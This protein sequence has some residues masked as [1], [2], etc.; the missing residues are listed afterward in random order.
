MKRE[1]RY[2]KAIENAMNHKACDKDVNVL[3]DH[4]LNHTVFK[5]PELIDCLSKCGDSAVEQLIQ[6]Y[7][8]NGRCIILRTLGEIGGDKS[9]SYLKKYLFHG[10]GLTKRVA[11]ESLGKIKSRSAVNALCKALNDRDRKVRIAS[12]KALGEIRDTSA[13]KP[14][15][16]AL[17]NIVYAG[18]D[19][20]SFSKEIK[21]A[22]SKVD[23]R[24][25]RRWKLKNRK[26]NSC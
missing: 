6:A 12:A 20:Y 25:K 15:I 16:E 23:D 14:L 13:R 24:K 7:H 11:A 1:A 2:R 22:L 10:E 18:P 4:L 17:K 26:K 3:V 9:I 8:N 19:D 21:L 5:S